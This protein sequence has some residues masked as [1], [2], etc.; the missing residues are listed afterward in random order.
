[1]GVVLLEDAALKICHA[2]FAG[3]QK[4]VDKPLFGYQAAFTISLRFSSARL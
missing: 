3:K 1:M 2:D 4:F